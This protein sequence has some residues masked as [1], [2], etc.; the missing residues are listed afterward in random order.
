MCCKGAERVLRA[1]VGQVGKGE[2]LVLTTTCPQS[3]SKIRHIPKSPI[4]RRLDFPPVATYGHV[5]R[6]NIKI[7]LKNHIKD[8]F[9]LKFLKQF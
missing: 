5:F 4:A 1:I 8:K 7:H 9:Q 2:M 6:R 3:L